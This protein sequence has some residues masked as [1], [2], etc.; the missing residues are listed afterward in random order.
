MSRIHK[1]TFTERGVLHVSLP[2][3]A[4][5]LSVGAQGYAVA[6]WAL[7]DFDALLPEELHHLVAVYTG[8]QFNPDGWTFLGTAQTS[9]GL[10]HHVFYRP[11]VDEYG[12][13]L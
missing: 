2:E 1:Y 13:D 5:F 6:V 7:G 3:G 8:A 10:V 12:A 4:R 11:Y 9:D